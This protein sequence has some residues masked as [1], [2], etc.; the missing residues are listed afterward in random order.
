MVTKRL[1]YSMQSAEGLERRAPAIR[2]NWRVL[3]NVTSLAVTHGAV[4][5]SADTRPPIPR[6]PANSEKDRALI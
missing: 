6:S 4:R 1:N 5:F 2:V 3:R